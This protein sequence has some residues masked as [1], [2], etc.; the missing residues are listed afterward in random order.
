VGV[1]GPSGTALVLGLLLLALVATVLGEA[2]RALLA[3]WIRT[4][5][6][7]EAVERLLLDFFLGGAVLY[8]VAALPIGAFSLGVLLG[9]LAVAGALV[10]L[11]A[12]GRPVLGSTHLDPGQAPGAAMG[13]PRTPELP[14]STFVRSLARPWA[15]VSLASAALL[16][17]F[18]VSVAQSVGTGNTFDSSLLTLYTAQ[19]LNLHHLP[20]T[21]AP[22]GSGGV[23]YPQGT[24]VWLGAAQLLLGLP[25][26][27]TSLLVTPLFFSLAPVGGFVLGRRT[28]GSDRGGAAF[29]LVLAATASWT[30]VL[31]GGSN[32]FVFAFPV[33]LLLAAQGSTWWRSLPTFA[34]AAGF[35]LLLGY[36]AALNPVG[37]EWLL[38][39]LAIGGAVVVPR[40][41]G[42]ARGFASRWIATVGVALLPL[43]PTWYV[44]GRGLASR[45]AGTTLSGGTRGISGSQ[46]VGSIDP[47][48]FRPQD[49]LLS[50]LPALRL[51][52]AV[53][54]TV[55]VAL[56]VLVHRT[57]VGRYLGTFRIL[58][59]GGLTSTI[60]LLGVEWAASAV[61]GPFATFSAVASAQELS[62]WLFTLYGF[63]A[64]L[65]LAILLEWT[66]VAAPPSPA[67][68][69]SARPPR[70]WTRAALPA[71]V[72]VALALALLVPGVALTP[73][74]LP[75]VLSQLYQDFGNVTAAD[76]D[77]LA[78]AGSHVPSGARV[79]VAPGSVTG[80]LPAYTSNVV[81]LYPM[82]PG[83]QSVNASYT[84]V[85]D[86]LTHDYLNQSGFAALKAL[87]VAYVAVTGWNTVLW[88]PFDA[89][90]LV[91]DPVAF[92]VEFHEGDAWLFGVGSLLALSSE[93][94][95][96]LGLGSNEWPA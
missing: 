85:V 37:A 39:A 54:L 16:L 78:Y 42:S 74:Q 49:V 7:L 56:L 30:R 22:Y 73:V 83:W 89:G 64:A 31:V 91:G 12:V 28:L 13:P 96:S 26:A 70:R 86:Q 3:R 5:R 20:V 50:P 40:F 38:I 82:V 66:H 55:G 57:P 92:S 33:V 2:A 45:G 58:F 65:P 35:G 75:S 18:E 53:L 29:A 77:L 24:T 4:W 15:I 93:P 11:A 61:G 10:L 9:L 84:L 94:P 25:G 88:P 23:L 27:R 59:V 8:L 67:P 79:L 60:G 71:V 52:L 47:F 19:L 43:L 63:G 95:A 68:S 80:F 48:L 72:P 17:V 51:E 14:V 6:R 1:P 62:I 90:P 21:L 32:D 87:G 76:F 34:D 41:A 36:S 81:L 46:F 44:W 69:P